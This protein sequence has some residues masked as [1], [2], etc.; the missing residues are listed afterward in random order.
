VFPEYPD[1]N[2]CPL[3][4]VEVSII[5]VLIFFS[6]PDKWLRPSQFYYTMLIVGVFIPMSVIYL[7]STQDREY[8]YIVIFTVLFIW[9]FI[10]F[11]KISFCRLNLINSKVLL[12]LF[13]FNIAFLFAYLIFI[14]KGH[15][16]LSLKNIYSHRSYFGNMITGTWGY[17]LPWTG[18]III[19]TL[20]GYFLWKKNLLFSFVFSLTGLLLFPLTSHKVYIIFAVMPFVLYLLFQWQRPTLSLI[21]VLLAG[22]VVAV[23]MEYL[24]DNIWGVALLIQRGTFK[25]AL[26]NFTYAN[27][28]KDMEPVMLA[29]SSIMPFIKNP[30]DVSHPF[31]VGEFLKGS[32][33][34]RSNTGFLGTG[35]AHFGLFGPLIFGMFVAF[36]LKILDSI[37]RTI[38]I[39]LVCVVSI[40]PFSSL[41]VMADF[42]PSLAT[43]GV[44]LC[45]L[46]LWTS[47]NLFMND[48]TLYSSQEKQGKGN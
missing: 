8:F 17:L 4:A 34:T 2:F 35:Y 10:K 7:W 21:F 33:Q 24:I 5:S 23:F 6:V 13:I 27:L 45:L 40:G 28:F 46:M 12:S 19:P 37:S 14:N 26:L 47:G 29:N 22:F 16:S 20:V 3:R 15:Y 31:L 9:A 11:P 32:L 1:L 18:K 36:L 41:L 38:P 48:F 25:P 43:H 42:L 39:W 44:I 30:Y